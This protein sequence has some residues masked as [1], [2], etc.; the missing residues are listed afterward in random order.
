MKQIS[1]L[2]LV[3]CL[4]AEC[5]LNAQDQ[6]S[7]GWLES[8]V[9]AI[10]L[11]KDRHNYPQA[12]E[13]YTSAIQTLNPNQAV[14]LLNLANERGH[15][16]LKMLDSNNA[17]K[18][19]SFVLNHPQVNREQ[20]VDALWG[21]GKANLLAGKIREF[22]EDCSQLEQLEASVTSIEDNKDYAIYKLAPHMLREAKSQENFINLLMMRE[23]I[24]SEKEVTFTPFGLVIIKKAK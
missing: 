1:F 15:L 6:S 10:E 21:R 2:F 5:L 24:K 3:V 7:N 16:Y 20:K 12:I 14:V 8:W 17:I 4:M 11:S 19:F 13:N 23:E 18:D 22:Q 9:S